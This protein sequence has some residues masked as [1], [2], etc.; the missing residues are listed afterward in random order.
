M[1]FLSFAALILFSL[2]ATCQDVA[3]VLIKFG[4]KNY[5]IND[6]IQK[7]IDEVIGRLMPGEAIQLTFLDNND[8]EKEESHQI[9]IAQRRGQQTYAYIQE[10]NFSGC[11][12]E[13]LLKSKK[14]KSASVVM[15]NAD[16]R[17][18]AKINGM[19]EIRVS[20]SMYWQPQYFIDPAANSQKNC[21]EYTI[22]AE[23][24]GV[25]YASE[26]TIIVV[27]P[28]AFITQNGCDQ[29]VICIQEYYTL[30]DMLKAGLTTLS[31]NK[32]LVSEGM[33]YL[34]ATDKCKGFEATLR[35]EVT[36]AMPAAN[37][38]KNTRFFSGKMEDLIID[39]KERDLE[40]FKL[41]KPGSEL[42]QE[43]IPASGEEEE[44]MESEAVILE[45]SSFVFKTRRM[46][47]INCDR[48]YE[49]KEP[50]DLIVESD[51]LDEQTT[52]LVVMKDSKSIIPGY[53]Y[54]GDKT[55]II[56]PLPPGANVTV[57]AMR[58]RGLDYEFAAIDANTNDGRVKVP[59]FSTLSE[60]E[61][62]SKL[63][64]MLD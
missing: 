48:Y 18:M 51:Q 25:V 61:L 23:R 58:A 6:D 41:M 59:S 54:A 34:R 38:D 21:Q 31:D 63:S 13:A 2:S 5:T 57:I 26:G 49:I 19:L 12:A 29:V 22:S 30:S 60:S 11:L 32:L 46:E 40:D 52:L 50:A 3:S 27:P 62:K 64:G 7:Q 8:L 35:K 37:G 17:D 44:E 53:L 16:L 47:W 39:W 28:G 55:A 45:N 24:G 15:S 1:K 9:N 42:D 56:Q 14:K 20:K 36:I 33:I 43:E 4:A 10:Q